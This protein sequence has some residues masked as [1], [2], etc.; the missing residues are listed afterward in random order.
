MSTILR[1]EFEKKRLQ[2]KQECLFSDLAAI[3]AAML[4]LSIE[5]Q[6]Y[7]EEMH[8]KSF[9]FTRCGAIKRNGYVCLNKLNKTKGY[10]WFCG[11]HQ[12]F[13][14]VRH[15]IKTPGRVGNWEWRLKC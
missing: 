2:A 5:E 7:K 1:I 13:D 14:N 10:Y 9:Q 12:R 15:I 4:N 11:H 6:E 8:Q 3:Q